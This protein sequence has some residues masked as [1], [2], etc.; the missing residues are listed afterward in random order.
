MTKRPKEASHK[1]G[2]S[3]SENLDT[4]L[5]ETLIATRNSKRS[6]DIFELSGELSDD[7]DS[8]YPFCAIPRHYFDRQLAQTTRSSRPELSVE[9]W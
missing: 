2:S 8:P 4:R 7:I 9:R 3:V 1:I 6:T 5:R